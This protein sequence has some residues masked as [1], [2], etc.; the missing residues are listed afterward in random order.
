MPIGLSARNKLYMRSV[1]EEW[2]GIEFV[3]QAV[4]LLTWGQDLL[5]QT[6]LKTPK[7]RF[8]TGMTSPIGITEYRLQLPEDLAKYLSGVGQIEAECKVIIEHVAKRT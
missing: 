1:A 8:G 7:R 6:K 4:A 2:P 3:Q 5:L